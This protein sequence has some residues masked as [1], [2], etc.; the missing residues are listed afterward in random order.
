MLNGMW[1]KKRKNEGKEKERNW[2]KIEIMERNGGDLLKCGWNGMEEEEMELR[3]WSI[4][5]KRKMKGRGLYELKFKRMVLDG[6]RKVI[7]MRRRMIGLGED[8]VERFEI[9][10]DI[11]R[12]YEKWKG[13][14]KGRGMINRCFK[15]MKN[16]IRERVEEKMEKIEKKFYK[17]EE[18]L[19]LRG[20]KLNRMKIRYW[21]GWKK[22]RKKKK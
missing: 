4:G 20:G 21:E 17:I 8:M 6:E 12:E 18:C 19:E 11:E 5:E 3:R 2:R 22:K 15:R 16:I 13:I 7:N 14:E 10:M 1:V 9:R